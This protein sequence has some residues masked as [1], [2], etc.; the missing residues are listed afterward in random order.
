MK[1]SRNARLRAPLVVLGAG[2]VVSGAVAIGHTWAD[3]GIAEVVAVVV[4]GA[5]FL[6]TTSHSDIGDIYADREDERQ[7]LV[8]LRGRSVA[9]VVMIVTAFACA[10]YAVAANKNYWQADVI[11]S[12]G[13]LSYFLTL[14]FDG[15]RPAEAA[16]NGA[17]MMA[18]SGPGHHPGDLGDPAQ[19]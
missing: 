11:G 3:A 18:S 5:L 14:L 8:A 13:G 1:R 12:L 16:P 2:T 7:H 15:A 10:V 17:G 9:C 4:S 19:P 6:L